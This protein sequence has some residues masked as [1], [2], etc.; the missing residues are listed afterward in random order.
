MDLWNYGKD[1][2]FKE[3]RRYQTKKVKNEV[4]EKD[5][6]SGLEKK[7]AEREREHKPVNCFCVQN[8]GIGHNS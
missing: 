5:I 3:V 8:L 6:V 1:V 2:C 7:K 4:K